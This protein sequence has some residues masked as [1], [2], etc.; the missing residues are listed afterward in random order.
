MVSSWQ[1]FFDGLVCSQGCGIG[2]VLVSPSGVKQ[3]VC[4]WLEF[5][6]SKNQAEYEGLLAGL[7]LLASMQ[8]QD[9]EAFGDTK[10]VVQQMLGEAQCLDGELNRYREACLSMVQKMD[11][12]HMK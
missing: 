8:A 12:F 11:I 1:L 10:L 5:K 4:T 6:C 9:V 3:E 2:Y 7:E